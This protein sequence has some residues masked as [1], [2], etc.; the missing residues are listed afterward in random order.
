MA[1]GRRRGW[2]GAILLLAALAACLAAGP[3]VNSIALQLHPPDCASDQSA[4]DCPT[5]MAGQ[6]RAEIQADL[7]KG[8]TE[9]QIIADFE[10]K[11][12]PA[13]LALP[14]GPGLGT[15][16]WW[17]PPIILVIGAGVA[18]VLVRAWRRRAAAPAGADA[19]AGATPPAPGEGKRD[20]PDEVRARM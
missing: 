19:E 5:Q 12:G 14:T 11:Y 15:F 9:Q 2:L 1:D 8:Q 20:I 16:A 3:S 17:L 18:S 10:Q 6:F 13:V 7:S 4:A